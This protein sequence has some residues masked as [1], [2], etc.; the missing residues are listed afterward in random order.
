MID[1]IDMDRAMKRIGDQ[2]RL[3]PVEYSPAFSVASGA[4]VWFKLEHLQHTGSFKW[5][6]ALN[7]M[8]SL[9]PEERARGVIT[10]S[11]GNHGIAVCRAAT[12]VGIRPTVC[13]RHGVSELRVDLIRRLGG[14]PL[15]YGEDP[16]EAETHARRLA[17]S[18]GRVFVSPYNDE[19][20]IAGQGTI[21]LELVGQLE[22]IDA[23]FV[24][25]GGGGLVSGIASALRSHG[26]KARIVGCW[27]SNSRAMYEALRVGRI[28]EVEERPTLSDSTAG[29]IEEGSITFPLCWEAIDDSVLVS[30]EEIA[31]AMRLVADQERWMIEGAAAV[32]V[33]AFLKSRDRWRGRRVVILLCGRNIATDRFIEI[34]HGAPSHGPA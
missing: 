13:M 15:F 6:G 1:R 17:A 19:V 28:I 26:S 11:N 18:D 5:R 32:A 4:E 10:A 24:A 2:T 8:L 27:P 7:R 12:L 20:V 3:T 29:G 33:A 30:E 14:E 34:C 21:G 9:T 31:Q 23:L 16:L 22:A 25:V